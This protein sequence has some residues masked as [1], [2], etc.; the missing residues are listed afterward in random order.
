MHH[1]DDMQAGQS[2][3]LFSKYLVTLQVTS[4]DQ[5]S[6]ITQKI[7]MQWPGATRLLY[8]F[9]SSF[10]PFHNS[11]K[12]PSSSS[13]ADQRD[14]TQCSLLGAERDGPEGRHGG[15]VQDDSSCQGGLQGQGLPKHKI[16]EERH[17]QSKNSDDCRLQRKFSQHV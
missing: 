1:E 3:S 5:P 13:H 16:Y 4:L 12:H 14:S 2:V 8:G 9:V 11:P 17:F 10:L 6:L 15:Q 7:A